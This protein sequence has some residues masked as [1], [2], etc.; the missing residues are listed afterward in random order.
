M[1]LFLLCLDLLFTRPAVGVTWDEFL[2]GQTNP[3]NS[4]G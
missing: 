2:A 1:F 3:T 4:G